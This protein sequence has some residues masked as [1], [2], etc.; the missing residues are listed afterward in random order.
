MMTPRPETRNHAVG[1]EKMD[2]EGQIDDVSEPAGLGGGKRDPFLP[3]SPLRRAGMVTACVIQ[4][5]CLNPG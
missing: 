5:C 1:H 4:L 3:E 2:R